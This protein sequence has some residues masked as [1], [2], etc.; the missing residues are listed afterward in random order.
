MNVMIWTP[1]VVTR[2]NWQSLCGSPYMIHPGILPW[3]CICK[4][5]KSKQWILK[6][7]SLKITMHFSIKFNPSNDNSIWNSTAGTPKSCEFQIPFF[8]FKKKTRNKKKNI[9]KKTLIG[10]LLCPHQKKKLV[11]DPKKSA[12]F[13]DQKNPATKCSQKP[14]KNQ[15]TAVRAGHLHWSLIEDRIIFCLQV[16]PHRSDP[17]TTQKIRSDF[18]GSEVPRVPWGRIFEKNG[19]KSRWVM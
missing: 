5:V 15:G 3:V 13:H 8:D 18:H 4:D 9:P 6:G 7:T 19:P 1:Q 14:S 10:V 2:M 17:K 12:I 11:H 16:G